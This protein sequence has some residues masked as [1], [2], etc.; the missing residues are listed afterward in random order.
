M[1]YAASS[2]SLSCL[3][4]TVH[5]TA[6]QIPADYVYSAANLGYMPPDAD[7]RGD[8]ADELAS[9]F[10]LAVCSSHFA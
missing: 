2:L 5:L 10:E 9:G 6:N 7:Y 3:E 1:L 8:I 4:V